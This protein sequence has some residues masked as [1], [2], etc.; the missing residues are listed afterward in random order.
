M[1]AP[2]ESPPAASPG[3]P[4]DRERVLLVVMLYV[5][6]AALWILLSDS[7][8]A[9]LF[10]NPA[11][12]TLVSMLKGCFF[13]TF[14]A[15]LLYVMLR[16]MVWCG[17]PTVSR[18]SGRFG[19]FFSLILVGIVL[20][21]VAGIIFTFTQHREEAFARLLIIA[22]LKTRLI[23]DW[24]RERLGDAEFSSNSPNLA[25][26]YSLWREQKDEAAGRRLFSRLE[27]LRHNHGFS[28]VLL[29]DDQGHT[30]WSTEEDS[31]SP[32]VAGLRAGGGAERVQAVGPFLGRDGRARL[33]F[34]MPLAGV[35]ESP[36]WFVL[37][38]DLAEWLF[39]VLQFWPAPS[40]SGETLL[41]R[42]EGDQ[43]LFLN[44]LRHQKHTA[45]RLRLPL[46][47]RELL[48]AQF[49]RGEVASG[50][51]L[52]GLDY[53]GAAAMGVARSIPG[54]DWGLIAKMDQA[55][56][57]KQAFS[58]AA[59]IVLAGVLALIATATALALLRRS[60]QLALATEVH[61]A[62]EERLRAL[63]LLDSIAESSEDAIFAKDPEGRYILFNQSAGR[64]VG[65]SE[66][67]VLGNDD[68]A[69]FPAEQA[70]MV[71]SSDQRI[72]AAN[73]NEVREETLLTT[74]GMR[75]FLTF[76]GV[77]RNAAGEAM[78]TFGIARDVTE[79]KNV[80]AERRQQAEEVV[81]RNE[82]LERFNRAM[83]GR[84][85][86]MIELKQRINVLS[87][88]LGR[89]APYPLG[90]LKETETGEHP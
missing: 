14:T 51:L 83:V 32:S 74:R 8:V 6:F 38:A 67:E 89:E 77:L 66:R 5:L 90:F 44:E 28:D 24:M 2:R 52:S 86:D 25:N 9:W 71:R 41:F 40:Q 4:P 31:D 82:E 26:D 27:Q 34:V 29:Q 57:Y 39:P 75:V 88:E 87:L 56:L 69:I 60:E 50:E 16:R 58:N 33:D 85:R 20:S 46:N 80:E 1:S 49:L 68:R 55:E 15:L 36:P 76:K 37:Q 63:Q 45:M 65:K 64:F 72:L 70:E 19:K 7:L 62:R 48:S 42:R 21:T 47:N 11:D 30:L 53:R 17:R 35:P 23:S 73:R 78:G 10:R 84:E 43:V 13:V 3:E 54:T 59:W 18:G 12:I 79:L 61:Q 22:D 81:K